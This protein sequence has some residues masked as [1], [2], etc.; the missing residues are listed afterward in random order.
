MTDV[1]PWRKSNFNIIG[2][3]YLVW[4]IAL[5]IAYVTSFVGAVRVDGCWAMIEAVEEVEAR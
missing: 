4:R 2:G 1:F 5:P 3:V